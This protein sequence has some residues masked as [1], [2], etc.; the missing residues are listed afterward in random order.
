MAFISTEIFLIPRI[1]AHVES[2]KNCQCT[3]E[4]S[5]SLDMY[6]QS[7]VWD[8]C[9]TCGKVLTKGRRGQGRL[10]HRNKGRIE[11]VRSRHDLGFEQHSSHDP[12]SY[13]RIL[14]ACCDTYF[15]LLI[16]EAFPIN[17]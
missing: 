11:R 17:T 4:E 15:M 2:A 5:T 16:D 6:A 3:Y 8:I 9:A 12:H 14:H 1:F 7:G 13:M 10:S